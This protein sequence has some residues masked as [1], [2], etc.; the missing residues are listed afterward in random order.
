MKE[1]MKDISNI[2]T[3]LLAE[4]LSQEQKEAI[5]EELKNN[6][7][8]LESLKREMRIKSPAYADLRYPEIISL[9]ETQKKLLNTKTAFF[10]YS[11]SEE[12]SYAFVITRKDFTIFPIPPRDII[13]KKVNAIDACDFIYYW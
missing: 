7:D 13:Q 4:E 12:N 1:L 11:I 8:K 3:R 5:H 6:E 9:V 2:Y 10:A